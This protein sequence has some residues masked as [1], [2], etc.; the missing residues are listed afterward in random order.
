MSD[1]ARDVRSRFSEVLQAARGGIL[2]DGGLVVATSG[3]LDSM[4]LLHLFRFGFPST[5]IPIHVAHFDH[6]MRE[7]SLSDAE[8][9]RGVARSWG[10][11]IFVERAAEP[12]R[13][14]E[15]A[16][17]ARYAFLESVRREV[18]ADVVVTGHHADDQ[19]ETVL[20]RLLR[21]SGTVGLSGMAS[22]REPGLWRP[23]LP[24]W[25][26]ELVEYADSVRLGWREDPSNL[27]SAFAR[28]VIRNRIIPEVESSVA[29][30]ARRSL[31][32]LAEQARDDVEAW[33]YLMPRLLET[34]DLERGD[35]ALS[36][37]HE[38]LRRLP[39]PLRGRVLRWLSER[40]GA[41]LDT[42]GTRSAAEF[43]GSGQSGRRLDLASGL[44]LRREL[45]RIVLV[46]EPLG[47]DTP[48][49]ETAVCETEGEPDRPLRIP[50]ARAGSGSVTLG[51]RTFT[52]RWGGSELSVSARDSVAVTAP[53]F[54]L[55]VRAREAG[56]RIQLPYGSKKVKKLLLEA[57]IPESLRER[58]PVFVDARGRVLW[59]P[60][61]ATAVGP[62]ARDDASHVLHIGI[63]DAG[64]H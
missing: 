30:G 58:L 49:G 2:H 48:V 19:A 11:P 51:G 54:P 16:R 53:H 10:L 43:T 32:R 1:V 45:D 57:R 23:L 20:F 55:T 64:T 60:G 34:L 46:R 61:V 38:R 15:S 62:E 24:F 22:F 17:N 31:V 4:A 14:E 59:I 13:S 52:V 39:T 7:G 9:V 28:N 42:V 37:D 33:R 6:G 36:V 63:D 50:G 21:G 44:V 12:L 29:P 3:G 35:D 27:E 5:G 40:L 18:D 26:K 56:D 47:R 25:K 41:R 8:W